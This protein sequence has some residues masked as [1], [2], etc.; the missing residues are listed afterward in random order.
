[1][2]AQSI[3]Q[4]GIPLCSLCQQLSHLCL[5]P[6]PRGGPPEKDLRTRALIDLLEKRRQY[7]HSF[8]VV[9]FRKR[10]QI[11]SL[12]PGKR[13]WPVTVSGSLA[14]CRPLICFPQNEYKSIT[15]RIDVVILD[16]GDRLPIGCPWLRTQ[17]SYS[18]ISCQLCRDSRRAGFSIAPINGRSWSQQI[19]RCKH[20]SLG[21][22]GFPGEHLERFWLTIIT[23]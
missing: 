2:V 11:S 13:G 8:V 20:R 4:I 7:R 21:R 5:T 17:C 6:D 1:M 3:A 12:M 23:N 18:G 14:F 15:Q 16:E 10:S 22:S 19:S 9:K